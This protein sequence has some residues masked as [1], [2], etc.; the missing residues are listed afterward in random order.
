MIN[1]STIS[2]NQDGY[3]NCYHLDGNFINTFDLSISIYI[4]PTIQF[5]YLNFY[6]CMPVPRLHSFINSYSFPFKPF[7]VCDYTFFLYSNILVSF[8][9]LIR[10]HAICYLNLFQ[11]L[12]SWS[13]SR[14]R[15]PKH[16]LKYTSLS[17]KFGTLVII[18]VLKYL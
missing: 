1:I 11:T 17:A 2:L 6:F 5:H 16:P 15:S 3:N 14:N 18:L 10:N 7:M 9:W 8:S 4:K 13:K 12:S